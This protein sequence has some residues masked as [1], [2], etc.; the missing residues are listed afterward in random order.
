MSKVTKKKYIR[1]EV[2]NNYLIPQEHQTIAKVIAGRGNNL[3]QVQVTTG[4]YTL[5]S[6]PK[7]F[8]VNVFVKHGDFVLLDAIPE[9]NKVTGEITH[10]F[11]SEHIKYLLSLNLWPAYF[12]KEAS[13]I[14][15]LNLK[16]TSYSSVYDDISTDSDSDTLPDNENSFIENNNN[17]DSIDDSEIKHD[18]NDTQSDNL[19]VILNAECRNY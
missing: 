3:H 17:N 5:A 19:D 14:T 16:N 12:F 18:D 15:K 7:K 6:M 10:I 2:M 4:E 8:R 1:Q 11:F 9:G 13:I